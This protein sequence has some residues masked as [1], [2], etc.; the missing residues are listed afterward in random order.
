MSRLFSVLIIVSVTLLSGCATRQYASTA[1][2]VQFA[3]QTDTTLRT[4]VQECEKVSHRSKQLAW[5][6]RNGWWSRNS[7]YVKGADYG[8]TNELMAVT[9]DRDVTGALV[10]AGVVAQIYATA[11]GEVKELLESS[12]NKPDLCKNVLAKYESGEYD[13][14]NDKTHFPQLLNL[15]KR[16][17]KDQDNLFRRSAELSTKKSRRHGRS[18]YTVEKISRKICDSPEVTILKAQWPYEVYNVQCST[19]TYSLVRCEWGSCLISE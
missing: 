5:Q 7:V 19:N 4:W 13:F 14:T 1:D 2:S 3:L 11:D 12:G 9:S 16:A 15:E 8:L 18:L 10:A 6:A 17:T